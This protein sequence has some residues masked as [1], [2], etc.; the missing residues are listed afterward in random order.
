MIY[1][2][3]ILNGEYIK[4]GYTGQAIDKRRCALQ[5]GNPYEI[6]VLFSV[7]GSLQQE[8]SIH[9]SLKEAFARVKVFNNPTN[10]W[11]PGENPM[12]KT[13]IS[14]VKRFGIDHSI[15]VI[16]NIHQ[17]KKRVREQEVFTIRGLE[18]ALRKRGLSRTEAKK[19]ISQNKAQLMSDL[20][21]RSIKG[22]ADELLEH[23]EQVR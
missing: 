20:C 21:N 17:W 5:T 15:A 11:Y 9:K 22:A 2:M 14:S 19:M 8:Q 1:F 7:E 4:I 6:E 10:E 3:S 18:K 16:N 13:L 23:T 12:I